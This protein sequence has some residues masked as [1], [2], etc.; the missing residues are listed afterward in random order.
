MITRRTALLFTVGLPAWSF[1]KEF[2]NEKKPE[3]WS[4]EEIE[5]LLNRSPW[6]K[7]VNAN[8]TGIAGLVQVPLDRNSSGSTRRRSGG[9][10]GRG[11]TSAPNKPSGDIMKGLVRWESA[12]PILEAQKKKPNADAA[13]FY[14][15]GVSGVPMIGG[16]E[17]SPNSSAT[18]DDPDAKAQMEDR[19]REG[20]RLIPHG[21]DPMVPAKVAISQT[22]RPTL[23]FFRRDLE[24]ITPDRREV[25]FEVKIGALEVK[26]KFALHEMM[27]R[28]KLEL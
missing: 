12:L 27:Y 25:A 16:R 5:T 11:D 14:I 4:A 7:E 6:A 18:S 20:T 21:R 10:L 22:E 1:A 23:I 28:G 19:V 15:L 3:E 26:T 8:L 2:W 9:S 17:R 24:P 13:E